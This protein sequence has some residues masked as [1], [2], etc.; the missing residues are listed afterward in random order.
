MSLFIVHKAG[1]PLKRGA[2]VYRYDDH[3]RQVKMVEKS[4][5]KWQMGS[6]FGPELLHISLDSYVLPLESAYN[7]KAPNLFQYNSCGIDGNKTEPTAIGNHLLRE[8]TMI[9][10]GERK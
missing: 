1:S 8:N 7:K 5:G 4:P 10:I 2:H 3:Y 9:I 6:E